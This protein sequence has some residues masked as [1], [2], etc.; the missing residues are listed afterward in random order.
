MIKAYKSVIYLQVSVLFLY[1]YLN[2]DERPQQRSDS[3]SNI[4]K[5]YGNTIG[6][7]FYYAHRLNW[8]LIPTAIF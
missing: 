2:G 3:N 1:I 8:T 5:N 6:K 7:Y 4:N